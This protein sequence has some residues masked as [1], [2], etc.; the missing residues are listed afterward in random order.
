MIHVEWY[1][2]HLRV[3]RELRWVGS[4]MAHTPV[5]HMEPT[6]KFPISQPWVGPWIPNS[7]PLLNSAIFTLR[8]Y[9]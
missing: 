4:G 9:R 8:N 6:S 5:D 1:T 7:I 2:V 3:E